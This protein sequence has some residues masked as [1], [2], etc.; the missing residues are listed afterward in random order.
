MASLAIVARSS[1][2]WACALR[3]RLGP[4]N[5]SGKCQ[6]LG[7]EGF[8]QRGSNV[9]NAAETVYI[10]VPA[11]AD[12]ECMTPDL[13]EAR[14]VFQQFA[15]LWPYKLILLSSA[16]IYG[17]GAARQCLVAE[18]YIAPSQGR[19]QIA[20]RWKSLE[21]LAQECWNGST[22]FTI[23][24]PTTVMDSPALLSRRLMRRWTITLA[25]HDPTVQLL[26]LD[27]LAQ[28]VLCAARSDCDGVFN[29]APDGVAPLHAAIKLAQGHRLAL[30]RTW[31]RLA[32]STEA[33][34][35]LRYSWTVSNEK[36]KQ[37]LGFNPRQSTAEVAR[38]ARLPRHAHAAT[39]P[40]VSFDEFGMDRRYIESLSWTIFEFLCDRYWRIE[41]KGLENVP[42][43]GGAILVGTHRGFIPWDGVMTLHLILQKTGRIPR[44]LTHPGL[45]KFPFI[46][47]FV[48]K[49]G[50]VVACQES[51]DRIL[52]RG[53]LLGVFPEG[54]QGAF[55]PYRQAYQV[56]CFGR[57]AFVK[58]AL[59]HRV[60]IIPYVTV[61][62]A[63]IYPIFAQI[64]WRRWIRYSD[65]PCFP[66]STF[67]FM[68]L[69]LPTKWHVHLL[70]AIH[71]DQRYGPEAAQNPAIVKEI[72]QDVRRQ[73]Q[74][75]LDEIVSRGRSWFWG[76]VFRSEERS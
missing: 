28:A 4:L 69:P 59:R 30:P 61:G 50:G 46:S 55:T 8:T 58:M 9:H 29:V 25:G 70:P 18:D 40:L 2:S 76:S 1:N 73:M 44:Y 53:E 54:V 22:P 56:R 26:S 36:I 39:D 34:E 72:S 47:N 71:L 41:A 17:T 13:C 7:V 51:A 49:L 27:D 66:I 21:A 20:G 35:Y 74:Q 64:K 52:A 68:P 3:D 37:R 10:Y 31:Q 14:Q 43:K 16:L 67:P 15:R 33:L 24:R 12:S 32:C 11:H 23:L 6:L 62:S 65:W 75:A 63:E 60:P 57:D 19:D 5:S 48:A 42:E 45:L 38:A